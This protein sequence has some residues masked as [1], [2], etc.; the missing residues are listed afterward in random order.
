VDS[1]GDVVLA[2]NGKPFRRRHLDATVARVAAHG[3]TLELGLIFGM[4]GETEETLAETVAWVHG[5]PAEVEVV[6]AAGARVY[7]GTPLAAVAAAEPGRVLRVGEGLLDPVAYC[8]LGAPRALA[9]RLHGLLGTRPHTDLL[10][11]GYRRASRAPS[12]AYRVVGAGGDRAA[13][14]RVLDGC[15]QATPGLRGA[16]LQI[17]LWHGRHDLAV[18]T[19]DAMLAAGDGDAGQLKRA[20]RVYAVLGSRLGRLVRR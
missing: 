17:A 5:L 14:Q 1:A 2:R 10:G 6:Y 3:I 18:P 19:I 4:P 9:R 13:W 7:P 12:E 15:P 11:V 8:S 16:L 20:R